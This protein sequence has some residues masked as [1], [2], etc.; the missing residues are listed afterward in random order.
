M[1]EVLDLAERFWRG[2]IPR[3]DLWRPTGKHEELAPGLVFFHT[4]AN[5]TA[6][7][8]EAGL[9]LVDTGN[10]ATRD[11]TFAAV[12]AVDPAPLAAAVYTH[13]HVDHACGLPPFLAEAREK[14]R[15]EPAIVAHRN[16]PARFDRYRMTAPWNGL[17]NSRQF[18]VAAAWPTEYQYPGTIYDTTHVLEVGGVRLELTHARG[19]TDDHTW[20]WWP[21]RRILFTG[22]L[23][24]W[25]APNAGNPQ[26]VQ[27]YAA[28][29]A[30]ALRVM[31]ERGAELL[32][33][34]HGAPVVGVARVHQALSDTALWLETLVNET[35]KRMN[36]GLALEDILAEVKP[37][38]HL[39]ERPYL[40]AVYDE[41]D[42]VI[43]NIWRLYGGWWDG[44][45]AHLKPAREAEIGLEVAA[46]AGGIDAVVAR[47][48]A[49]AAEGR[50][51]LASHLIDW[52]AAAAPNNWAVHDARA[53][54]YLARAQ[55]SEALMTR[56]IFSEA[57]RESAIKAGRSVTEAGAGQPSTKPAPPGDPERR[58][59]DSR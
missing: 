29:W 43:R 44:Q 33:P 7:R 36:A 9:V 10:F 15:P 8:T 4:W 39:S 49:L 28:E 1:G 18:S 20:L 55:N 54:I 19:E 53:D 40:Q 48:R 25:V 2:E 11:R 50:L 6:L 46:L 37:P 27:R 26:K 13:G 47:A 35:V 45:P 31:A 58:Q 51:A 22:D 57:A 34:G 59:A 17:I 3:R 41:P 42:Y 21:A 52:V 32:I 14:G 5:V 38:A 23:F 24:F 56:G 12:R 16:V 30:R